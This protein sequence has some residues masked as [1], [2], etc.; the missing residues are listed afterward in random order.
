MAALRIRVGVL[1]LLAA[2]I[3][4]A[5]CNAKPPQCTVDQ[6]Y[7]TN[8][9]AC[10]GICGT[11]EEPTSPTCYDQDSGMLRESGVGPVDAAMEAAS[12]SGVASDSSDVVS[13]GDSSTDS[14]VNPCG[15]GREMAGGGCDVKVPRAIAPL[16]T[17]RV[18]SRT[19]R[20][21]WV[22]PEGVTGAHVEVC[23]DRLC[24]RLLAEGD[25]TT[26]WTPTSD[27]PTGVAFWRVRGTVGGA[28]SVRTSPTWWMWV[29]ARS[30]PGGVQSSWGSVPDLNGDGLGDLVTGDHG[31]GETE[32]G[33]SCVA[34]RVEVSISSAATVSISTVSQV[35]ESPQLGTAFGYAVASAGD[36]NGDGLADVLVGEPNWSAMGHANRGRAHL[37]LSNT[38]PMP[39]VLNRAL[40]PQGDSAMA[41]SSVDGAGDVNGDGYSDVVVAMP[42]EASGGNTLA[43]AVGV[44]FGSATGVAAFPSQVLPG[45]AARDLFGYNVRG[46]GDINGDGFADV[47][48]TAIGGLLQMPRAATRIDIFLGGATGL[49]TPAHQTLV[50]SRLDTVLGVLVIGRGDFNADGFSDLFAIAVGSDEGAATRA[51]NRLEVYLGGRLGLSTT[52]SL[53]LNGMMPRQGPFNAVAFDS[54]LDGFDDLLAVRSDVELTPGV[55][56]AIELYLSNMGTV[57]AV[58]NSSAMVADP[59]RLASG[60]S[61]FGRRSEL[62][63]WDVAVAA[64][65]DATMMRGVAVFRTSATIQS[66]PV[67]SRYTSR[68]ASVLGATIASW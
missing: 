42:G 64:S 3:S 43:G 23:A 17:A 27:L 62:G 12:D 2:G 55:Q 35:I 1:S 48:V 9:R 33:G 10:V 36:V 37:F 26:E 46:I 31:N 7:D 15:A 50:D 51:P 54:N 22:L 40:E 45:R 68:P 59:L 58:P 47:A 41:G 19:P 18:T 39:L 25:A 49:R 6:R 29:P 24:A 14:G 13:D 16:S 44:Y 21:K 52:P 65:S 66:M 63:E 61:V 34:G 28:R 60:L 8:L 20:L 67:A 38:S 56:G 4:A 5:A 11:R 30:A 57:G 53:T 32:C